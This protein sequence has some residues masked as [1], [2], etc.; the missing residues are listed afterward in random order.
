MRPRP[1]TLALT[2]N[3]ALILP[4][5]AHARQKPV[6]QGPR[7]GPAALAAVMLAMPAPPQAQQESVAP[8]VNPARPFTQDQVQ[9]MVR[10]GLAD[11]SG[12]KL[13]EQRGLDFAHTDDFLQSLKAAGAS[14]ALLEAL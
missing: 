9:A 6:A 10:D 7:F 3:I 1:V 13:I 8:G 2:L 12:A 4:L 14:A 5:L 11:E